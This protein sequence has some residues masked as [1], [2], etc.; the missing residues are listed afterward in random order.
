VIARATK[1][2][3]LARR[4]DFDAR[5]QHVLDARGDPFEDEALLAWMAQH[6]ED[7]R[8]TAALCDVIAAA[9]RRRRRAR[10]LAWA[11]GAVLLVAGAWLASRSPLD[12]PERAVASAPAA[13][14]AIRVLAFEARCTSVRGSFVEERVR[15]LDGERVTTIGAG[16][17][18]AQI[19]SI[20]A[21]PA[22]QR[23]RF[24]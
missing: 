24:P 16:F 9:P 4:A 13:P 2:V 20:D 14:G 7:A 3:E 22:L 19:A 8:A 21:D 1:S 23:T 12:D 11:C 6:P 10:P 17:A 15:D 18:T 5:L